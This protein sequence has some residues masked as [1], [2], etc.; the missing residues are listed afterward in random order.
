LISSPAKAGTVTIF[1]EN[2]D[3]LATGP[4]VTSA[5]I[6]ST[7]NG[8]NVDIVG[9]TGVGYGSGLCLSPESVNCVDLDG[10][11]G[12]N[13]EGQLQLTTP[14]TLTP[15]S[16]TLSF[17][18]IGSGARSG[19]A[20]PSSTTTVEFGANGCTS[21]CLY[22]NSGITLGQTDVVDGNISTPI[23]I[24]TTQTNVY[25]TF[26]SDTPGYIGA[27]LDNVSLTETTSSSSAPEP[28]TMVLLGSALLGLGG[29][30]RLRARRNS[31]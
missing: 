26:I 19:F 8:T 20:P 22:Y 6:F 12:S 4:F 28:G 13:P 30:G 5:G 24:S 15:G 25:L 18:L 3:E 23:T 27:L 10:S 14:I 2:F 11:L 21:G 16:Y 17:Q 7:I 29:L 1:S 9:T 31:R